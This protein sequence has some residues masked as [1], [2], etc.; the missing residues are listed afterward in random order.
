MRNCSKFLTSEENRQK[1]KIIEAK[2][3]L[4]KDS[5]ERYANEK[6]KYI[7]QLIEKDVYLEKKAIEEKGKELN[8][9]LEEF[10]KKVKKGEIKMR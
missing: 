1:A 2:H 4:I 6:K 8:F 7:K 10:D 5:K 3:C 9:W